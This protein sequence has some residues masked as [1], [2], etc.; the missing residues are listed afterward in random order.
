MSRRSKNYPDPANLAR[1][2]RI[3]K[4]QSMQ[5]MG[6]ICGLTPTQICAF[7]HGRRGISMGASA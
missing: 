2:Q 3:H 7:E 4:G 5:K 1:Y 6:K